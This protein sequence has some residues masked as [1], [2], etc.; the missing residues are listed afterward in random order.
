MIIKLNLAQRFL[1]DGVLTFFTI[2]W[3]IFCNFLFYFQTS[4]K[5]WHLK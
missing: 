2:W 3:R 5:A 1:K 4:I